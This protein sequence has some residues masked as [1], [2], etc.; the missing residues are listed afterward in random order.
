MARL[1]RELPGSLMAGV[2]AHGGTVL[3][4]V[5][6]STPRARMAEEA[7]LVHPGS[8]AREAVSSGVPMVITDL[9]EAARWPECG[10]ALRHGGVRAIHCQ[11]LATDEGAVMGVLSVYSSTPDTLFTDELSIALRPVRKQATDLLRT[12]RLHPPPMR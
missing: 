11:P 7:Q 8:P 9:S 6:A 2:S 12:R 4:I 1:L 5:A 10:E 3:E